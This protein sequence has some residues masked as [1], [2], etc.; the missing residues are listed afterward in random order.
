MKKVSL[1]TVILFLTSACETT[2]QPDVENDPRIVVNGFFGPDFP[3]SVQLYQ[4]NFILD[5]PRLTPVSNAAVTIVNK[6]T[7]E[8]FL[9]NESGDGSYHSELINFNAGEAYELFVDAT[10]LPSISGSDAIPQAVKVSSFTV[11]NELTTVNI[12]GQGFKATITF[13]DNNMSENYYV[14]ETILSSPG[15]VDIFKETPG[16][17]F[18]EDR[19]IDVDGNNDINIGD[20]NLIDAQPVLFFNDLRFNGEQVTIDFFLAPGNSS[21][22]ESRDIYVVLKSVS[23]NY[24]DFLMTTHSQREVMDEDT[25]VEPVQISGN[26]ENGLGVF[27]GFSFDT[28]KAQRVD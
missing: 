4:T 25:F 10:G 11:E 28:L 12:D 15:A 21:G 8:Q 14:I 27:A 13:E 23:R 3:T 18:L 6:T 1:Y 5:Q 19:N 26:I 7:R 2:F 22:Q 20:V 24:H 16:L 17:I 9:L